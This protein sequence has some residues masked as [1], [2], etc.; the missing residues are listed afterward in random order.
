MFQFV[1]KLIFSKQLNFEEGAITLLGQPVMLAPVT[2]FSGMIEELEEEGNTGLL[3]R[4]AE[5][6]GRTYAEN[7]KDRQDFD[8]Q[9][10]YDWGLQTVGFAGLG[11]ATSEQ[12]DYAAAE[13]TI[14]VKNST[15]AEELFPKAFT[16]DYAL[17]GYM[18]GYCQ[19]IFENEAVSCEETQCMATGDESCVFHVTPQ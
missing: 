17:A 13:A 1:K 2:L 18:A 9:G 10:L 5:T 15:V 11:T 16:V 3:Y 12:V 19:I 4:M 6:A 14:R 8:S 7:V